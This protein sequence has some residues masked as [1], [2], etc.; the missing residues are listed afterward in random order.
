M[1]PDY[2]NSMSPENLACMRR[3][4]ERKPYK[5]NLSVNYISRVYSVLTSFHRLTFL[6]DLDSTHQ[7]NISFDVSTPLTEFP[8]V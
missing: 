5:W 1:G 2:E 3:G 6:I 7:L 4:P 8:R